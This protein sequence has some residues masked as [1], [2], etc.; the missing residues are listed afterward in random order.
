MDA[1]T[2][3]SC[4]FQLE[5]LTK[6]L[7][8]SDEKEADRLVLDTCASLINAVINGLH[9]DMMTDFEVK[10]QVDN[11]KVIYYAM[12]G[13]M[14]KSADTVPLSNEQKKLIQQQELYDEKIREYEDVKAQ[15][16]QLSK[17]ISEK[18]IEINSLYEE[19]DIFFRKFV[20]ISLR[21]DSLRELESKYNPEELDSLQLEVE[22]L[23]QVTGELKDKEDF[24][25]STTSECLDELS[26]VLR[27]IGEKVS[28]FSGDADKIRQEAEE[29]RTAI[30]VCLKTYQDYKSWFN[31]ARTPWKQLEDNIGT[32]EYSKL[33]D[34]AN[35]DMLKKKNELVGRIESDLKALESLVNA[36]TLAAQSDYKK[37]IADAGK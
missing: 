1:F 36:C 20:E 18:D 11:F 30:N 29:F 17:D 35:E 4:S 21:L 5:E 3:E 7:S 12:S 32:E 28:S 26:S 8:G 23:K 22:R 27:K 34:V 25:N 6:V 37:I 24:L 14:N 31:V 10:E 9:I 2:R 16:N 13:F 33:R 19:K 15:S